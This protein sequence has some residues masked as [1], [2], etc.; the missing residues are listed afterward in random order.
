MHAPPRRTLPFPTLEFMCTHCD[1]RTDC[2]VEFEREH[3]YSMRLDFVIEILASH[4]WSSEWV[5][6]K[7]V[8]MNKLYG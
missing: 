8:Q 1:M 4:G 3:F 7:A 6:E 2:G 5:R